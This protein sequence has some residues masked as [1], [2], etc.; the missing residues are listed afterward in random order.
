MILFLHPDG[1][2]LETAGLD[3]APDGDYRASEKV[4]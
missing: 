1:T 2:R 3:P 4:E